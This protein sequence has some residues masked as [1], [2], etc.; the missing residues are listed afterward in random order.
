M[1]SK[2]LDTFIYFVY[3]AFHAL[4]PTLYEVQVDMCSVL[5]IT[6][7]IKVYAFLELNLVRI[8]RLYLC[9]HYIQAYFD[10]KS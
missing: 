9:T 10:P 8:Q 7:F 5:T 4:W 1:Y 6:F 3:N 2:L